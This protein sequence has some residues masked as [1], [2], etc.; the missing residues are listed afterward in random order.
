MAEDF[1]ERTE[2]PTAKRRR[3]AREQ[4][5]VLRSRE[6]GTALVVMA[7]CGWIALFGPSLV[8]ACKAVMAASFQFGRADIED[9]EPFHPLAE[10][11]WKLAPSIGTLF[12]IT[13]AAAI[14]SQAGL[15]SLT[16]NGG[17]L[18]PKASRVNPGSGLKRIFGPQGWIEL[19][20]GLLK[21]ALLGS[22][23]AYMLWKSSRATLGLA[24]SDING[25]IGSLGGT[26]VGI[27]FAMAGG[28]ALI[29]GVDVP[30][31]VIRLLR[32]LRMS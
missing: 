20:K 8:A 14:L 16:F 22:I 6:F 10:A 29:A 5:D 21:V 27:L 15:G 17:L 4:G 9:F 26:F 18:A 12:A 7:G 23:G 24:S 19:G 13:V 3:D 1:G 11:G 32:K 31:Q 2:A 28:L 25:A 30:V